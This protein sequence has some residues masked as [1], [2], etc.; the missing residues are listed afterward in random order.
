[1]ASSRGNPWIE[2]LTEDECWHL[3]SLHTIG[4]VGVLVNGAPEIYPLNF[5][6]AGRSIIFRTDPG[7]KLRGLDS[8]RPICFEVDGLDFE[9]ET[10][11]SVLVKGS[12]AEMSAD[13]IDEKT[14][15]HLMLWSLGEKA[16]WVRISPKEVTGRRLSRR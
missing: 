14:R 1:M 11:W 4:R 3:L 7:N 8:G 16:H 10:G 15:A 12:G 9:H 13:E 5:T 6:T 2:Y